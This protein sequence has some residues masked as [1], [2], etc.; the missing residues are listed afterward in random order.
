VLQIAGILL[1]AVH[2]S[3]AVTY[4]VND[5]SAFGD[6]YATAP[7]NDLFD[8]LTPATP[9]ATL[10]GVLDTYDV[11][12]GDLIY[13]DTGVYDPGADT[14]IRG[15]DGGDAFTSVVIQGST[16]LAAGGSVLERLTG[17]PPHAGLRLSG[18]TNL[19]ARDLQTVVDP[20][21]IG[22]VVE[23]NSANC[24]LYQVRARGGASIAVIGSGTSTRIE[25]CSMCNFGPV[26]LY[27]AGGTA[28]VSRC[29]IAGVGQ[30]GVVI[31]SGTVSMANSIVAL[32][33]NALSCIRLISGIY[34][35]DF[36]NL[37]HGP[38][39]AAG[40]VGPSMS[41]VLPSLADWQAA[42]T[43]DVNSISHDPLFVDAEDC[44]LHLR[45][46]TGTY[47]DNTALFAPHAE[48]SPCIDLGDPTDSFA[49]ETAPHG[50]RINLG[51][52][53]NTPAASRSRTNGALL[54][55][56]F[57]DGG[58]AEGV[59]TLRWE[60]F[61]D[62][63]THNV[64]IEYSPDTGATWELLATNL[65]ASPGFFAWDTFRQHASGKAVWRVVSSSDPA[66]GDVVDNAFE[67]FSGPKL[68]D[69]THAGLPIEW[70]G[71]HGRRYRVL[72]PESA[73]SEPW[74]PSPGLIMTNG[75]PLGTVTGANQ[76]IVVL[77]TNVASS[78]I[79]IY[80]TEA[81]DP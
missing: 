53:A 81:S 77:D 37:Y 64:Y 66:V 51:A 39:V 71:E 69:P 78:T 13:V 31:D 8:G 63:L 32:R 28:E 4:Y 3:Q 24:L 59:V 50:S 74:L 61:E 52:Y 14:V 20:T 18:T 42:V 10:Q 26:G 67:L 80:A 58:V 9:M 11:A 41:A 27:V 35:G 30:N 25:N 57:N 68:H 2:T 65:P 73:L 70:Y 62:A 15:E 49:L 1:T 43:Q 19:V 54:A 7:G 44:D 34:T 47:N 22:I 23:S 16:N 48:H 29:T 75:L 76:R 60:A 5:A 56:S 36:N 55:V 6:I 12:P 33:S 38:G 21:G 40:Q 79:R 72:S 17:L 45:S 46:L